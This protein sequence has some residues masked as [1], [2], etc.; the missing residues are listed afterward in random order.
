MTSLRTPTPRLIFPVPTSSG[1]PPYAVASFPGFML[2][3][4]DE[5]KS[6]I[7]IKAHQTRTQAHTYSMHSLTQ[8]EARLNMELVVK[9]SRK[10]PSSYGGY[11]YTFVDDPPDDTVCQ[12]CRLVAKDPSQMDC[13][14]KIYCNSCLTELDEY[15][16]SWLTCPNCRRAGKRFRDHRSDRQIKSL[17]I[18]CTKAGEGCDWVGMLSELDDHTQKQCGYCTV[19][20]PHPECAEE[21]MASDLR[22]HID[23]KCPYR[24]YSCPDCQKSGPYQSIVTTHR[25]EC[26]AVEVE[27]P[28][29]CEAGGIT[30]GSLR[31]HRTVC[32][33]EVVACTYAEAGCEVRIMRKELEA[34]GKDSLELHLS[35]AMGTVVSLKKKLTCVEKKVSRLEKEVEFTTKR[36]VAVFRIDR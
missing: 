4:G 5:T 12:I 29:G 18:M 15:V 6:P 32:T 20:C 24:N 7:P 25:E 14:G 11:D 28:N 31:Q 16:S 36:P 33:M 13:C 30:R 9:Q 27:C 34:H 10:R 8:P 19:T 17:K 35:L 2:K 1:R 23:E 21:V 26:P 3:A 22:H